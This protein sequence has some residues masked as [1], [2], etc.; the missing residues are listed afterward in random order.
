MCRL[1]LPPTVHLKLIDDIKLPIGV[2]VGLN[3]CLSLSGLQSV[4]LP[5]SLWPYGA[6]LPWFQCDQLI[7]EQNILFCAL[8]IVYNLINSIQFIL[9]SQISQITNLPQWAL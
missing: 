1:R 4:W 2:N 5:V 6:L 8:L 3:G 7:S 9:Y